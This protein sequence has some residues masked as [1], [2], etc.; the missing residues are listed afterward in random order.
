[1]VDIL[2]SDFV[3]VAVICFKI[4]RSNISQCV[5]IAFSLQ[6]RTRNLKGRG[7]AISSRPFSAQS[8]VKSEK[9]V[10]TS[11]DVQFSGPKSREEQK[12]HHALR[13]S[14]IRISPL[15]HESFVHLSAKGPW[16]RP[17]TSFTRKIM[18]T[19]KVGTRRSFL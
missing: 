8:Q 6:G 14:F 12:S 4:P 5:K 7:G 1:M 19:C 2:C 18:F 15:H 13:L 3:A 16:I 11:A 17:C 10:N 9:K